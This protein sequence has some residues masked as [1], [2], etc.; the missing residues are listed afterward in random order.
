MQHIESAANPDLAWLIH[1][2]FWILQQQQL[3]Q[4]SCLLPS[5][6][7]VPL[8]LQSNS[9]TFPQSF[10]LSLFQCYFPFFPFSV[11][12]S[13]FANH[14]ANLPF[15]YGEVWCSNDRRNVASQHLQ[16][17]K[18]EKVS[19]KQRESRY[20]LVGTGISSLKRNL[21]L[22]SLAFLQ[23]WPWRIS[24]GNHSHL[25]YVLLILSAGAMLLTNGSSG[26]DGVDFRELILELECFKM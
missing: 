19:L 21:E 23:S 25:H 22:I 12:H 11:L 26:Q 7:C 9:I 10:Q 3:Q 24:A 2:S 8:L 6:E 20:L 1:I 18:A 14:L 13:P 5:Y 16:N 4:R 15:F 17:R